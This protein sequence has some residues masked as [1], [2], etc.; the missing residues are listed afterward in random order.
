MR[1]I[2]DLVNDL[3]W[4]LKSKYVLKTNHIHNTPGDELFLYSKRRHHGIL[5]VF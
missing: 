3:G 5:V 1:F 2:I 4:F